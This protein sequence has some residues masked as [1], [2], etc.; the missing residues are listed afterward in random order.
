[1]EKYRIKSEALQFFPE[2][3]SSEVREMSF[4]DKKEISKKALE[5]VQ[6]IRIEYGIK[7]N[8]STTYLNG[9]K[10]M[11]EEAHFDFR[12]V[13]NIKHEEYVFMQKKENV[14]EL[15]DLMQQTL[16]EYLCTKGF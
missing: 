8:E 7:P 11:G 6:K 5:I 1:M 12:V 3:L 9:W 16:S 14:R 13:A 4:W 15:M 10:S 2:M